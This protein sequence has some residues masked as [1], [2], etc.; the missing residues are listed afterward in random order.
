MPT[1]VTLLPMLCTRCQNP[2]PAKI[3]EV[4]WVCTQCGQGLLLDAAKGLVQLEVHYSAS[5]PAGKTG[6]PYWVAQGQVALQRKTYQGDKSGDMRSF[7]SQPH[8]FFVPAVTLPLEQLVE[9]GMRLL[10]QPPALT[11]GP[12]APFL[13]VTVPPDDMRPLAEFVVFAIEAERKDALKELS[14]QLTM[15]TPELWVL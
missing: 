8:L 7:W 11:A 1:P 14:I 10:R 9:V 2:L 4:A 12:A 5:L 6:S 13:P 15:A 3:D